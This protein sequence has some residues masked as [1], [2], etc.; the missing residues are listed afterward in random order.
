MDGNAASPIG[1]ADLR[2]HVRVRLRF[3]CR[4]SFRL[5]FRLRLQVG[6]DSTAFVTPCEAL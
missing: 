3:R 1:R 5:S 2:F 6:I 4:F